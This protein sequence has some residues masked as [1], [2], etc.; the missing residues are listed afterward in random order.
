ME[1]KI[2]SQNEKLMTNYLSML[3]KGNRIE[4][5]IIMCLAISLYEGECNQLNP[6]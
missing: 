2:K 6:I 3:C 5:L 1:Q 4:Q